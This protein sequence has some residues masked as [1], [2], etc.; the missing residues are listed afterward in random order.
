MSWEYA[1]ILRGLCLL[2]GY[3]FGCFPCADVAAHCV[4]GTGIRCIGTGKPELKNI[5]RH[6]GKGAAFGVVVGDVLKTLLACWFCYKLAAP[7]LEYAAMLYGGIGT[8]AGHSWPVFG[9]K[10]GARGTTVVCAWIAVSLPVSGMLCVLAGGVVVLGTRC[11]A[12]GAVLIPALATPIALLQ[13]GAGSAAATL[14]ATIVLLWQYRDGFSVMQ[15][16]IAD[17]FARHWPFAG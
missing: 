4:A 14:A 8:L 2:A 17:A 10:G 3:A 16:K 5:S 6:L 13:Y 12:L 1:L 9:K 11:F 7:E 15:R